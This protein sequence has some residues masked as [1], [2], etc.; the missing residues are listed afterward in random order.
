MQEI[1]GIPVYCAID[2]VE[3]IEK[4]IPNP[5]NPNTHNDRQIE[6]LAKVIKAQGWR[7]PVTV[8]TRSGY[9]VRGHGRLMAAR[10]LGLS[11]VP[12]DYQDYANEAEEWADLIA[13]NR[14]AELSEWNLPTLKDILEEI[15]TGAI[16][17]DLTG[18]DAD[19]LEKLMTQFRADAQEDDFD[20]E[21][22]AQKIKKPATKPG[23]I[24]QLG[25]HRLVCGDAALQSDME[26]LMD[27]KKADML[28]T[29]PPYNVDYEGNF[30]QGDKI[31]K[32]QEKIWSGGIE[33]D[34]LSNFGEWLSLVYTNIDQFLVAGCAIYIWHLSGEDCK[35]FWN[36]WPYSKWHFQV[37]IVWNK[38]SLVI[39]RWDY[40]PQHESCMY[41]W[42]GKNRKWAGPANE[43]TVWNVP[44]QQGQSGGKREHPTQKPIALANRAIK[45]H[46]VGLVLDC[47]AGS[48]STLIACEQLN[49]IC[50]MMEIDPVYCD[51]IIK[52][53]EKFTGKKAV[54]V[55]EGNDTN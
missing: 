35:F 17:M 31:L 55:G 45:N 14:I 12:V 49:R 37:D 3:D 4:V 20:A 27:G 50:Y 9:I 30:K 16:D 28:F 24:W 19:E 26:K 18:F 32:N 29:D 8:S 47:F 54:L 22:E 41:G 6:L 43:P 52:R 33:N 53:W 25:R 1:E 51:V 39:N 10:K 13:D 38:L 15:D 48:G 34:N 5:R 11:Q 44:R 23:D 42:K 2:K 36:A 40:K 7:A 46:S 21:A